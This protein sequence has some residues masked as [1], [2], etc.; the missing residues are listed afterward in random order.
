MKLP[1]GFTLREMTAPEVA[2]VVIPTDMRPDQFDAFTF[3]DELVRELEIKMHPGYQTMFTR[4]E[5]KGMAKNGTRV[6]KCNVDPGDT[7]PIGAKGTV[8]GS[9]WHPSLGPA[10]FIEWDDKP[11]LAVFVLQ[12]KIAR[13]K[14]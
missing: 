4:Q 13:A 9:F 5:R 12:W 7:R 3:S 1:P 14:E 2:A 10:Y 8:L 11:R 6:F